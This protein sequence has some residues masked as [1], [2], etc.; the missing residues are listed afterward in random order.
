MSGEYDGRVMDALPN[1]LYRIELDGSHTV[2]A[3]LSG[4][5]RMNII[6]ILPGDRVRVKVSSIDPYRGRI[7]RRY[8]S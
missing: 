4:E 3:H 5:L 7:V 1:D 6:R 2:L 8:G